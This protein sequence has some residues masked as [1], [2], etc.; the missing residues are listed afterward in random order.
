MIIRGG[1][2]AQ[3]LGCRLIDLS[4]HVIFKSSFVGRYCSVGVGVGVG[5]GGVS[6]MGMGGIGRRRTEE[7]K[8]SPWF[9]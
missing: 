7:R 3:T 8:T 6:G 9:S 4:F 5:V 2:Q 1:C